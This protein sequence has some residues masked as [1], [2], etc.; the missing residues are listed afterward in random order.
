MAFYTDHFLE[1][2]DRFII[3]PHYMFCHW[4]HALHIPL[5]QF[6]ID[7]HRLRVETDHQI[8]K[9][10]RICQLC[11]LQEVEV[12][13]HFIFGCP[14]YYKIIGRF[15]C[16][17][18]DSQT[19][20]DFFKYP[21]QRCLALYMQEVLR[22]QAHILLCPIKPDPTHRI[23]TFFKVLPLDKGTKRRIDTSTYPRS[24]SVRIR[25]TEPCHTRSQH[26]KSVSD[27]FLGDK[28]GPLEQRVNFPRQWFSG[29]LT[30]SINFSSSQ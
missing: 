24:K 4:I 17:F 11:H 2:R 28:L 20:I 16:L 27:L 23:T 1:L 3:R 12:E 21:D 15:H 22:F 18:K 8:D 7:S 29:Q 14:V 5:S 6:N 30:L 9:P 10:D 25:G 26:N 19:L 13:V